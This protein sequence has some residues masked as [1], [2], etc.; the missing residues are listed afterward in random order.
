M[1]S[2]GG[3]VSRIRRSASQEYPSCSDDFIKR[4]VPL[5]KIAMAGLTI[6]LQTRDALITVSPEIQSHASSTWKLPATFIPSSTKKN[7]YYH[8]HQHQHQPQNVKKY[9]LHHPVNLL[10][11]NRT[12]INSKIVHNS[13]ILC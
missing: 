4:I 1:D 11:Q 13:S 12:P 6:M 10:P 9:P 8:Q 2:P 3:Y 7:H 5:F